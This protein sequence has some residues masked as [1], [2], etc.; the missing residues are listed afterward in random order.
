MTKRRPVRGAM[1]AEALRH[2]RRDAVMAEVIDFV[3][4]LPLATEPDL[5]WAL[6]DSIVSQQVS[7]HAAAAIIRRV[8]AL[9]A[10]GRPTP[11]EILAA[12]DEVLRAA[13]LSRAKVK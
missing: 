10:D 7:V 8:A 2:L 4:D 6:V 1:P 13:G 11:D 9:G 12:D 3:G 5:W